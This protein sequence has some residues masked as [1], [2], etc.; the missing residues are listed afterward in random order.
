MCIDFQLNIKLIHVL[1]QNI[2]ATSVYI[3]FCMCSVFCF[4]NDNR[5]VLQL[6]N[7]KFTE[8]GQEEDL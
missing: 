8:L 2:I 6:L 3:L 1:C 5:L 4:F 7:S